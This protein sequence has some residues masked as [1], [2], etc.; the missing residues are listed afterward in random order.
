MKSV[1]DLK[2]QNA[3]NYNL[4]LFCQRRKASDKLRE[5]SEQG[6]S[7]LKEAAEKRSQFGEN[8]EVID[9]VAEILKPGVTHKIL[10]HKQC[11]CHF[12]DQEKIRR[13][14]NKNNAAYQGSTSKDASS[15]EDSGPRGASQRLSRCSVN[16]VDWNK[17]IF[18]QSDS[19]KD[20]LCYVMTFG[21]SSRMLKAAPLDYRLSVRLADVNDLIASE[22]KYHLG[23][24]EAF[25]R[26]TERTKKESEKADLAFIWLC[27]ELEQAATRG[28]V[29]RLINV[30]ERYVELTEDLSITIPKS[31][32]SRRTT[33][34]EKLISQLN[35][36]F[37]FIQPLNVDPSKRQTL[38]IPTQYQS[39]AVSR[40]AH[41]NE[42]DGGD[43][44]IPPYQPE[45][46]DI[47]LHL[48]H[49]ALKIRGDI[50]AKPGH[51]G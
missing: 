48:V 28:L 8:D 26:S 27:K 7:T 47:S 51:K 31:F 4:C 36:E 17:C 9:R 20:R 38:L 14:E 6:L 49:V 42:L 40:L 34:K 15:M 37:F 11:Y 1:C 12:T 21:L 44:S 13:L 3:V 22:G 30:W 18:C 23:C 25:D 45:Q 5:A 35:G 33:F 41:E 24:L 2:K 19:S 10:W 46:D 39:H 32:L 50:L 29:F 16:P 43:F